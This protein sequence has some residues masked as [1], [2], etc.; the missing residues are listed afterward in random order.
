[1]SSSE[2]SEALTHASATARRLSGFE[3]VWLVAGRISPPFAIQ[4]VVEGQGALSLERVREAARVVAEACP[5]SKLRLTGALGWA[6]WVP[7]GALEVV[8][9]DGSRWDGY[10]PEGAPFLERPLDPRAGRACEVLFVRGDPVRIVVRAHHAAMDGVATRTLAEELFRALRGEP[11]L[12]A[13][14]GPLTDVE[15]ARSLGATIAPTRPEFASHTGPATETPGNTWARVTVPMPPDRVMARTIVAL[16]EASVG[17]GPWRIA[18]PVDLRRHRDGLRST[19]N[20][21]GIAHVEVGAGRAAATVDGV[22]EAV[23]A[24]LRER[25]EAV[26]VLLA[27]GVRWLPIGLMTA[28]G[29]AGMRRERARGGFPTSGT[30]SNL[31]RGALATFRALDFAPTAV[32]WVPPASPSLPLFMGM[33]GHEG[34][35]ELCVA[36]PTAFADGGRLTALLARVADRLSRA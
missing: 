18:V 33:I 10:G 28:V 36:A 26:A 23:A 9:V 4:I 6:R 21:T 34:G 14:A 11:C 20:L 25:Q 27:D 13:A 31:G 7:G 32:F 12:A 24:Q 16:A 3:R 19:A 17:E 29:R 15:V 5:G 1:M 2:P 8:E 22:A 30:V 35:L